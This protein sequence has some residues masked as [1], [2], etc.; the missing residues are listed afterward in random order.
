MLVG[1][2]AGA[3]SKCHQILNQDAAFSL[4][5]LSYNV[6]FNYTMEDGSIIY[7]RFCQFTNYQCTVNGKIRNSYAV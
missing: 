2:C 4:A 1:L 6:D 5:P 7:W 3:G